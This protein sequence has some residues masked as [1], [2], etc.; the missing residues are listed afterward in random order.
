MK[1]NKN[2]WKT[3]NKIDEKLWKEIRIDES[4]WKQISAIKVNKKIQTN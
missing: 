2:L 3:M 4:K 1:S